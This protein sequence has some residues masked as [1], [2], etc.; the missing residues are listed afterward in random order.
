MPTGLLAPPIFTLQGRRMRE[1]KLT[2]GQVALVDDEDYDFL[3]QWK[4]YAWWNKGTGSFYA[5]RNI[6]TE[7]ARRRKMYIHRMLMG[8]EP[9][10]KRCVDHRNGLTLD[11]RRSNL[12]IV[13][14]RQNHQ[15]RWTHREGK[16]VGA[17]FHK[18]ENKWI[19]QIAV[20]G[21]HHH[22]G[23]FPTEQAAHEKYIEALSELQEVLV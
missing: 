11:N 13:T 3:S 12:R 21:K 1:I 22:L 5:V 2:Q 16:L 4:W 15:N 23:Y 17:C 14:S 7:A 20:N 18:R 9:G 10:D 8:L 6:R 19:S